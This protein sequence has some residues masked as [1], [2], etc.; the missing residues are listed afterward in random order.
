MME[1][2]VKLLVSSGL[3]LANV[4]A[5]AFTLDFIDDSDILIGSI[6]FSNTELDGNNEWLIT[7]ASL[8]GGTSVYSEPGVVD[9]Y[10]SLYDT[11]GNPT[12]TGSS[13]SDA[14]AT[15]IISGSLGSGIGHQAQ[16]G[17]LTVTDSYFMYP[18]DSDGNPI[19]DN[20]Q[21]T[22]TPLS[23]LFGDAPGA[24]QFVIRDLGIDSQGDFVVH[25]VPGAATDWF[26]ESG[27]IGVIA[28]IAKRKKE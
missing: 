12:S 9:M 21:A 5:N 17:A 15:A 11:E 28:T 25:G 20:A 10:V 26:L 27:L 3:L 19:F 4:S 23:F 24:D 18:Y 1:R 22:V 7:P 2:T 8:I 6:R 16:G 14:T 13:W